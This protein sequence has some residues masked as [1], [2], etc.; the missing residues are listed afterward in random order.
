MT[1]WLK[2][3]F[4]L[5]GALALLH[6]AVAAQAQG[7][8]GAVIPIAETLEVGNKN[9]RP[10]IQISLKNIS[11]KQIYVFSGDLPWSSTVGG[12]QLIGVAAKRVD[13]PLRKVYLVVNPVGWVS[14]MP[15]EEIK[16]Q[17]EVGDVFP[18]LS[19]AKRLDD[20]LLFW[21]HDWVVYKEPDPRK[22]FAKGRF[23]GMLVLPKQTP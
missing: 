18:E 3:M 22:E 8:A 1:I 23:G 7:R 5:A 6:L 9:G 11:T 15:G 19:N 20:I 4:L 10:L 16:G 14:L 21:T 2:R 13:E 17:I 12:V